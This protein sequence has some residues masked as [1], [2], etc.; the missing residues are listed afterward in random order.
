LEQADRRGTI[1]VP[2]DDDG[3]FHASSDPR[4]WDLDRGDSDETRARWLQS[5]LAADRQS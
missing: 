4:W 5:W 3:R 1:A 2:V